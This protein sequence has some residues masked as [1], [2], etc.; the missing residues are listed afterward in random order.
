MMSFAAARGNELREALDKPVG[1]PLPPEA[2][3]KVLRPAV[4]AWIKARREHLDALLLLL[5][6]TGTA[7]QAG[8]WKSRVDTLKN[9]LSRFAGVL[10]SH[11]NAS[12][13]AR[14]F[15]SINT[16][17]DEKFVTSLQKAVAAAEARDYMVVY[18][19][20]VKQQTKDLET[21]WSAILSKHESYKRQEEAVI[22]Q[23]ERMISETASKARDLEARIRSAIG[24]TL[25]KIKQTLQATPE[26]VPDAVGVPQNNELTA[27]GAAVETFRALAAGV[28]TQRYRFETYFREEIGSVLFLFQ[29]FRADTKEFIDK[30]GYK[31]VLER[32]E[33]ARRSLD[34]V[35]SSGATS[36]G[37][38][39]DAEQFVEAAKI[40]IKGHA[41]NAKNTWDDF[42]TKHEKKFFGPVGP[43]F[44]KA[45]LDRDAFERKYE[46]LQAKNLHEL[47]EKWRSDIREVWD[48]DFSGL[49]PK[50]AEAYSKAL[51][52][53]LRDLDEIIKRPFLTRF[54]ETFKIVLANAQGK[55]LG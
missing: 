42:V 2:D 5:R 32:E 24:T 11:S 13:W 26:S 55:I 1:A 7:A 36:S 35:A 43:N 20:T 27:A 49:P 25:V 33:S 3:I 53:K 21:K 8:K 19:Q 46:R 9:D 50:V 48:V 12:E 31:K 41:N 51:I 14:R 18:L 22:D 6:D 45:L 28:E 15:V 38:K 23:V 17:A 10:S 47:A 16:T 34:G 44:A 39:T 54:Q 4:E 40:L 52:A 37:N 30:F 29:D